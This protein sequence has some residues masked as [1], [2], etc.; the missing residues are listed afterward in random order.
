V[1]SISCYCVT[2]KTAPSEPT[3]LMATIGNCFCTDR[4]ENE[5]SKVKDSEKRSDSGNLQSV[6]R[7][8]NDA[9]FKEVVSTPRLGSPWLQSE[10]AWIQG[11]SGPVPRWFIA[12][13]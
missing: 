6:R 11:C 13:G 1:F 12:T 4:H 8:K 9:R 10:K 3:S 2:T 5:H 7:F